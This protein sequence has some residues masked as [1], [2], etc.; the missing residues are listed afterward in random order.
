M[1]ELLAHWIYWGLLSPFIFIGIGV[2]IMAI[3]S[4]CDWIDEQNRRD[5]K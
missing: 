3:G 5:H 2:A 4:F 1:G